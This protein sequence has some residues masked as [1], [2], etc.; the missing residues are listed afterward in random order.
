MKSEKLYDLGFTFIKTKKDEILINRDGKTVTTLR[1]ETAA[2][3]IEQINNSNFDD[4]Q[5]I[6]ARFTGNYKRGNEKFAKN[7]PRNKR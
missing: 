5:Q 3:F 7:H 1:N 2:Q 6:M 4:G